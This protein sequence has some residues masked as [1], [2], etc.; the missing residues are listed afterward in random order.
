MA[1]H[2]LACTR[3][4]AVR[5]YARYFADT[6]SE[7]RN[8]QRLLGGGSSGQFFVLSYPK[9]KSVSENSNGR[10][11]LAVLLNSV[12]GP[13]LTPSFLRNEFANEQASPVEQIQLKKV[14][15]NRDQ[16]R[17]LERCSDSELLRC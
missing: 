13:Q 6:L 2:K 7:C 1:A 16:H 8:S 9:W 10:L 4:A 17:I 11:V 3:S 5:F 12:S 14:S 15:V